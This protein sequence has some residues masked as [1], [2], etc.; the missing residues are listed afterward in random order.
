[1][2]MKFKS[3][4]MHFGV[5]FYFNIQDKYNLL[6]N[7]RHFLVYIQSNIYIYL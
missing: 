7:E 2:M 6:I 4:C 3:F 5:L 1:M